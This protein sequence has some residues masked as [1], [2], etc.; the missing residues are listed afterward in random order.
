MWVKEKGF[1]IVEL[2]IVIVVIAILAAI[3]IVAYNGIQERANSNTVISRAQAYIKGL[4]LMEVDAGRPLLQSCIAPLSSTT[5]VSGN[6]VCSQVSSWTTNA[7]YNETFNTD[8]A[9]FSGIS[10]PT[11][12]KYDGGDNPAGLFAYHDNWYGRNRGVLMYNTGPNTDCG[13]S[14]V[15]AGDHINY[16]PAGQNYTGRTLTYTN[17]EIEVFRY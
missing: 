9:K 12:G 17:C 11:L 14:P 10:E 1:T 6:R 16:A 4:R 8:L 5:I 15:I 7:P 2:L 3:S 13:L